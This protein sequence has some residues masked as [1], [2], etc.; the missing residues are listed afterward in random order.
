MKRNRL[1]TSPLFVVVCISFFS[2]AQSNM[3]AAGRYEGTATNNAQQVIQVVMD[4]KEV[5]GNLSG[6][7]NSSAGDFPI[8]SGTRDGDAITIQFD[9]GSG[10]GTVTAKLADN[11][12]VGTYS[13]ADDNG[14]VELKRTSGGASGLA[15]TP[16][17]GWN[18]WNKFGCNVSDEMIRSM[19]DAVVKS[20]MKDAGY[21][22]VN[23]DDCWQVSRDSSGNI[24]VDP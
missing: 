2:S 11:R 14:S 10:T 22:Y 13:T 8:V 16:P 6:Q 18:S 4:L 17:M 12:L 7:I 5:G 20:G 24:V 21:I 1:G 3:S 9:T 23:I 15:L 19:A